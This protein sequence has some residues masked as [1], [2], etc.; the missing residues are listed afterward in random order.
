[1]VC[2]FGRSVSLGY[3]GFL[4]LKREHVGFGFGRRR[5]WWRFECCH[6]YEWRNSDGCGS[7]WWAW[8]KW[9]EHW[10]RWR[11]WWRLYRL[12]RL[13]FSS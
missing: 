9:I 12:F 10:W 6:I 1:L 3:T 8:R 13:T 2:W 5:R 7:Y 4:W 11:L